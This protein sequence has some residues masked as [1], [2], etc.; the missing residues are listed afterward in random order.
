MSRVCIIFITCLL[1]T[2]LSAMSGGGA[3]AINIPVMLSLGISFPLATA[4][5]KISSMFWVLPAS[6]NYLKG[7]KI[8]WKFLALFSAIG[9]IGVY[10]GALVVIAINRRIAGIV[11]GI[12]ILS[13]VL[14]VL[15]KKEVGLVETKADSTGRQS[16]AYLFALILGFYESFFGSGNG[17][18]FSILTFHTK[19]FDFIDALGYY[20]SIA[21]PWEVLA[22][23]IF[24]S[25]GYFSISVMVPAILGSLIGG[26]IGSRYA[27]Y[28]GNKF[29]KVMFAVIGTALGLKLLCGL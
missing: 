6:S 11:V 1:A 21:F 13:L 22:V 19:G 4:A 2:A 24:L 18:L 14:Y 12:L 5:Q 23:V 3:S 15:L 26:Y 9:L 7:R 17:I 25:K 27:R 8:D 20:Y 16:I 10:L 28:K 29:I